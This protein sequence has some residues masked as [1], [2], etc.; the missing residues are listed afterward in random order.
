MTAEEQLKALSER[1]AALEAQLQAKS[2]A[3]GATRAASPGQVTICILKERTVKFA[4]IRDDHAIEKWIHDAE[5]VTAGQSKAVDTV[6]FFLIIMKV[7][8]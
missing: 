4:G 3:S 1:L 2:R 7:R 5:H 8:L 6:D